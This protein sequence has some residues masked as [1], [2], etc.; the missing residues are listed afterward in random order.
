MN[1]RKYIKD[2]SQIM[3]VDEETINVLPVLGPLNPFTKLLPKILEKFDL[4]QN[5]PGANQDTLKWFQKLKK[6]NL[7]KV[8]IS[9]ITI[10]SAKNS[11]LFIRI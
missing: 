11:K 1:Q 9:L 2:V 3:S 4:N 8:Y 5:I 7:A 6:H 10:K